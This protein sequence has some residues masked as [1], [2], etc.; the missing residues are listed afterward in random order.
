MP[1][2]QLFANPVRWLS[3]ARIT[4]YQ[5][6]LLNPERITF[7]NA[8]TLNPTTLLPNSEPTAWVPHNCHQIPAKYHGTRG[9]LTDCQLPDA[10]HIWFTD[11][12]SFLK[13]ERKT[14][15]VVVD[16]QNIIW[17]VA[18]LPETSA[19]KAE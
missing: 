12:S 6:L 7:G 19:Q 4:H 13:G 14:W 5:S 8:T 10:D 17:A 16:G 11:G 2:R 9:N 18:L 15:L 3:N 1:Q